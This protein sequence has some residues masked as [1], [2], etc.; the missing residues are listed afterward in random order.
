[1]V[2]RTILSSVGTK[3]ILH[4]HGGSFT[5]VSWADNLIW[6][7][8][9]KVHLRRFD[10][11]FCLTNEQFSEV[12]GYLGKTDKV[13]KILNYVNIPGLNVL[14]KPEGT[15][16]LLFIGRLHPHKGIKEAIE[17]VSKIK[18]SRIRF[19]I[20]GAGELENELKHITDPRIV[21]LGR[22][23][24]K[25]KEEYL[26]KSHVLL[27]PTFWPEGL[28]YVLLEAASYGLALISTPVGAVNEIMENNRNG[29]MIK[30]GD[31]SALKQ[32]IEKF[33]MDHTL[34]AR[35]GRESRDICEKRFSLEV[36]KGIYADLFK[37]LKN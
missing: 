18:D 1:M 33:L 13:R 20:M 27:L 12:S 37:R 10:Q 26:L 34:A 22:K 5:N 21:F 32:S 14:K 7:A 36:L 29:F 31:V 15:L 28:P 30:S 16:N 9:L 3:N 17:A 19:W 35:M 6:K 23:V 8:M 25:D 11:I 4:L 24:G 2:T